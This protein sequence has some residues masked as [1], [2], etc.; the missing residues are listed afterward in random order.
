MT[1]LLQAWAVIERNPLTAAGA[2]VGLTLGVL[3]GWL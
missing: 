3:Q 1:R 2:W